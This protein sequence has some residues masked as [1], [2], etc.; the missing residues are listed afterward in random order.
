MVQNFNYRIGMSVLVWRVARMT[1][2]CNCCTSTGGE[3]I[4]KIRDW[5]RIVSEFL[6]IYYFSPM[7]KTIYRILYVSILA[8]MIST[9]ASSQEKITPVFNHLALYCHDLQAMTDF[10]K[11]VLLLEQIEEPFKVGRH[12]WFSLGPGLSLHLI[13]HADEVREHPRNDHLCVSIPSMDDFI[14]HLDGI[15]VPYYNSAGD[16]RTRQTRPDGVQQIYIVDPE[17][18]WIEINDEVGRK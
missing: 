2:N 12:S 5:I 3:K 1:I 16:L 15:D 9:S 10:Y 11:D 4:L 13:G 8:I 7:K 14:A 6:Q 18:H 17:G